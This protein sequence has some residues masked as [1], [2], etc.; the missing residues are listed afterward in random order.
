MRECRLSTSTPITTRTKPSRM[1]RAEWLMVSRCSS[2]V[3]QR[4]RRPP[5]EPNPGMTGPTAASSD[6]TRAVVRAP[7]PP[8]AAPPPPPPPAEGPQ[9][10]DDWADGR[11]LR[12]HA[13][14]A[15]VAD[16]EARDHQEAAH[17]IEAERDGPVERRSGQQ[18]Q[19]G[20]AD[21]GHRRAED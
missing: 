10:R 19:E 14:G 11:L 5:M 7:P 16:E 13:R 12:L 3:A 6:F 9:P 8:P 18:P 1:K 17:R 20:G 4:S 2:A 21:D 15:A